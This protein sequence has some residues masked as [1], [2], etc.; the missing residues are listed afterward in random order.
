MLKYQLFLISLLLSVVTNCQAQL[1]QPFPDFLSGTGFNGPVNAVVVDSNGD[2]IV[3][4]GFNSYK[5]QSVPGL[6]KLKPNGDRYSP[7]FNVGTSLNGPVFALHIDQQGRLLVAGDFDFPGYSRL[8]RFNADGEVDYSLSPNFSP[9]VRVRAVT[10]NDAGDIFI[11]GLFSLVGSVSSP[12]LAKFN[13]SGQVDL[14]F[15][16]SVSF[17]GGLN[18]PVLS[19]LPAPD[20]GIVAGGVFTAYQGNTS[21]AY[22]VRLAPG[23]GRVVSFSDNKGEVVGGQVR[24]MVGYPYGEGLVVAG[25]FDAIGGVA[26]GRI[27]KFSWEGFLDASYQTG[28]GFDNEVD[29]LAIDQWS[30]ELY[31]SGR[32]S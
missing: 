23:G 8:M 3:G 19:L 28:A 11:G 5:G 1:V 6:V 14:A 17:A 27:A 21:D 4:G 20:G 7:G 24:A 26:A 29:A 30:G 25:A 22:L 10:T 12:Y 31:A 2:I 16:D 18:A 15:A 13:S 32:F 9:N